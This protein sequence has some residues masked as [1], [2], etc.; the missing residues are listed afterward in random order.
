MR[1]R[2]FVAINLPPEIRTALWRAA[3]P[4]RDLDVSVRWIPAESIHM[5]LKFLGDVPAEREREVVGAVESTVAGTS[6]FVL[7]VGGVGGF[8]SR[9]QTR[10]VWLGC[11]PVP[12]LEL[13]QD[14]LERRFEAIGFP[15]SGRPFRPHLTLGRVRRSATSADVRALE[16]KMEA[17][18]YEAEVDVRSIDVM[19]SELSSR[20]ARYT[21]LHAVELAA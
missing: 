3:Q 9:G 20:G 18:S 6:R 12:A 13:L 7:P 17:L 5:T 21:V 1:V 8:P 14:R 11:E 19:Q 16:P 4:L 10:V 15:I 2:L